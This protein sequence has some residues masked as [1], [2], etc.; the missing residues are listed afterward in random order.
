[1]IRFSGA[2]E[3]KGQEMKTAVLIPCYN[4]EITIA[5][6]IND[7]KNALPEAEIYVYD[8]NSKDRTSQIARENGAK[9]VFE[10]RQGKG[11]V[12]R[13]MFREIDADYYI[14]VDGDDTYPAE[15]SRQLL[16]PLINGEAD[17]TIG[18]RLSN[19]TYRSENK[20][21]FHNFGNNLV[22]SMI[23]KLFNNNITDIMTGYRG[24]NRYFVK[25]FPILSGGF[26]I[27]TE[28][29][30]H[31]LDKKFLIKE[32]PIDYRDRPKGSSSKLNTVSDGIKVLRTVISLFKDYKPLQFFS[33]L[34][35]IFFILSLIFGIPV[36]AEFVAAHYISKVPSAILAV[37]LML[38][39]ILFL[40]NGFILD[41]LV[42]NERKSYE[43]GLVRYADAE[44]KRKR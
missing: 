34:S 11:N 1:M 19:G 21:P 3:G 18:D 40:M 5:K 24:F 29:S 12:V 27:E 23:R 26:E 17:M 7:F 41:T 2:C 10:P 16:D 35:L 33:W 43:L 4:E 22:K 15:F 28:M 36:I 6:V 25:N 44:D 14:M 42:K 37:G 13:R 39:A 32:I 20:R 30:I 8:N 38:I 9:V 31:A